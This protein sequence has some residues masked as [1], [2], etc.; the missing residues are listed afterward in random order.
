MKISTK[1]RYALRVMID[2][3]Q[4]TNGEYIS[5]K[6]IAKRQEVSLKYLEMIMALLNNAGFV[7][8]ARGKHGGYRLRKIPREYTV[9]SILKLAEGSL[10]PVACLDCEIN[11][12]TRAT[13]CLTLPFWETLNTIVDEYIESVTLEDLIKQQ[14]NSIGEEYD[15]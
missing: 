6:D 13:Q 14:Q 8:S 15:I 9:G 2:L 3:A 11:S 10:A 4:H 5:L 7:I 1:G 12:C